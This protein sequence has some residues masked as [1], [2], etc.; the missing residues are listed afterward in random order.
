MPSPLREGTTV[1]NIFYPTADCQVV[2]NG[3]NVYLLNGESKI[4]VPQSKLS[5]EV[6]RLAE[7]APDVFLQ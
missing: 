4:Y 3:V 7:S 6:L 1:C 5:A 2:N